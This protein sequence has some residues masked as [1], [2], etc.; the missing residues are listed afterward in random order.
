MYTH[1]DPRRNVQVGKNGDAMKLNMNTGHRWTTNLTLG[2]SEDKAEGRENEPTT[3]ETGSVTSVVRHL[4]PPAH[5]IH[6][7]RQLSQG[8]SNGLHPVVY[9]WV[10]SE[11]GAGQCK[12]VQSPVLP[13]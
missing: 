13:I 3:Q 4:S 5:G 11:S 10:N 2:F 9:N 6:S 8:G 1:L 12:V 7:H